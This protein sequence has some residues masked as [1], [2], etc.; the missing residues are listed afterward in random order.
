MQRLQ[1]PST[2]K[3]ITAEQNVIDQYER[4]VIMSEEEIKEFR[5]QIT[6][7]ENQITRAAVDLEQAVAKMEAAGEGVTEAR[8][9]GCLYPAAARAGQST[10]P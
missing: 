7:S 6:R 3:K 8:E 1:L 4:D 10:V 5:Q 2:R 9:R